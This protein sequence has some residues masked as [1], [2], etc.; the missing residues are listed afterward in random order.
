MPLQFDY[1]HVVCDSK[2]NS[3]FCWQPTSP[4]PVAPKG[5]TPMK[6][7][8]ACSALLVL[9]LGSTA[10]AARAPHMVEVDWENL[11]HLDHCTH[12]AELILGAAS[13]GEV[14]PDYPGPFGP[15]GPGT[16]LDEIPRCPELPRRPWWNPPLDPI[17]PG[18][19]GPFGH[20]LR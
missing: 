9:M 7:L 4:A 14:A 15:L 17:N 6:T 1:L 16:W 2:T 11:D 18:C 19:G 10:Y 12:S 20:R 13:L 5:D 8:A 3:R